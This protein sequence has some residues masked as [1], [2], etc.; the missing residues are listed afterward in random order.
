MHFRQHSYYRWSASVKFAAVLFLVP[1]S[2]PLLGGLL[3]ENEAG[4]LALRPRP[5]LKQWERFLRLSKNRGHHHFGRLTH[6]ASVLLHLQ[7]KPFVD[8]P[9]WLLKEL[10]HSHKS[11]VNRSGRHIMGLSEFPDSLL[12][13]ILHFGSDIGDGSLCDE[14]SLIRCCRRSFFYVFFR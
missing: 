8:T 3:S 5:P 6:P 12:P 4:Q 9:G 1:S 7:G 13:V 11:G 10:R 14:I 2:Q